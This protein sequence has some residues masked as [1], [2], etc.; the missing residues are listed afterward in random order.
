MVL[1]MDVLKWWLLSA[2]ACL[3]MRCDVVVI[4]VVSVTWSSRYV[5]VFFFFE[6]RSSWYSISL[7]GV[8]FET[9]EDRLLNVLN[10]IGVIQRVLE[11]G[12]EVVKI[13]VLVVENRCVVLVVVEAKVVV[14]LE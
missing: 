8:F 2:A 12:V 5:I 10:F 1:C 11:R 13:L 9:V 6:G 7:V 14:V 3:R 4:G